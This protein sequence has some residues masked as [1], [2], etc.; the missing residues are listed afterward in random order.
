MDFA[1]VHAPPDLSK[2]VVGFAQRHD[3]RP[4]G[5]A[6]ELPLSYPLIQ[7]LFG[8]RYRMHRFGQPARAAAVPS[9]G[10]W[11]A[12][13]APWQARHTAALRA[14]VLILTHLGFYRITGVL[15]AELR[16][17]RISLAEAMRHSVS[18][19]ER[20]AQAADFEA[21]VSMMCGWLR[22]LPART[23]GNDAHWLRRVDR[24]ILRSDLTR[25]SALADELC[26][27]PRGLHAG[28]ASACGM[29]PKQ[30]LRIARLGRTLRR[31][32]PQPWQS[33]DLTDPICE[34]YDE[35]HFHREFKR[36]TT[37]SPSQYRSAKRAVGDPLIFTLYRSEE[38]A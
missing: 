3:H 34:Y 11:G 28:F 14:F 10:L 8:A 15:P 32:H 16:D 1:F 2:W 13:A 38:S 25:T 9:A 19:E 23:G 27:S 29:G 12:T 5:D 17:C 33:A 31:L 22:A 7:F 4:L 35:S 20:L 21:R 18:W 24:A 37:V 36:L 6:V 30:V 26:V